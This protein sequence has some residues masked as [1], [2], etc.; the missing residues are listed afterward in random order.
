MSFKS[1][2]AAAALALLLAGC[3]NSNYGT[4]QTIGGLGGAALGGLLGSQFGKGTGQLAMTAAGAVIGG[5]VG[6]EVGRSMDETD[7]LQAQQATYQA[8][9][10]PVGQTIVWNN[11]NSGNY[12]Q[13]TPTREGYTNNGE[14]CREFQ[15][16]VTVSGRTETAYGVACRQQDGTWRVVG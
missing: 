13:V 10:A 11:P 14:Y 12:G 7:R 8:Q 3:T 5:L 2:L 16:T 4:K 9:A 1:V 6:S 15:Q